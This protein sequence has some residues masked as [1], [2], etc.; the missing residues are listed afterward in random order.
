VI[1]IKVKTNTHTSRQTQPVNQRGFTLIELII[2][3]AILSVLFHFAA[4]SFQNIGA[5]SRMTSHIN[6]MVASFN[7]A[8]SEAVKRQHN[9]VICP[10][11]DGSCARQ[12]HWHNGWL[13]FIDENFN[14]EID[15]EE[16]IIYVEAAKKNIEI[17]S[18][19]YR[20]RVVFRSLGTSAGSNAS[21]VFCDHRGS[22]DARA[23]VLS[24]TGRPRVADK[25]SD[26]K[27]WK[28]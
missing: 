2:V 1:T 25:R 7:Y 26:G 13:M 10:N 27:D 18:S 4:P 5:N 15:Q 24:N 28:C 6:T 20:R 9:V 16:E 19:R 8:R 23:I 3:L 14:R 17:T 11:D 21:Y 22:E 12:P